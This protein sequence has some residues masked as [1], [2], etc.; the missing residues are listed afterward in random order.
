VN[1]FS[2]FNLHRF[3]EGETL[4][5]RKLN[6]VVSAAA[7]ANNWK[8]TGGYYKAGR[9]SH[10]LQI[11]EAPPNHAFRV[12]RFGKI[13]AWHPDSSAY[14][15]VT[16]EANSGYTAWQNQPAGLSSV[17]AADG[18]ASEPRAKHSGFLEDLPDETIVELYPIVDSAEN[19]PRQWSFNVP[20]Q[21]GGTTLDKAPAALPRTSF[22]A[23]DYAWDIETQTAN[24]GAKFRLSTPPAYSDTDYNFYGYY[25]DL[26][27]DRG[28]HVVKLEGETRWTLE[29]AKLCTT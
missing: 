9:Y 29:A 24:E 3:R 18:T 27:I 26:T 4:S 20:I 8:V 22:A 1:V 15:W 13:T 19:S 7:T 10:V 12:P 25:V 6:R 2:I 23:V 16:V 21:R 11:P 17:G 28:G 5:A 14:T